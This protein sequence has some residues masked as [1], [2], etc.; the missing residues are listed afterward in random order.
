M[1]SFSNLPI[2]ALLDPKGFD[3]ACG[4][5]HACELRIFKSG[6]GVVETLP[7]VLT[8]MGVQYPF[9]V[10]DEH[11][12]EAAGARVL[13]ILD[14]AGIRYK[15]VLLRKEHLEPDEWA[16][17]AV[18]LA[19]DPACDVVL[20]VGSGVINDTCKVVAHAAGK[21]QIIVGTAPSMDG[22]ASSSSSMHVSDVKTTVYNACPVAIIADTDI[23]AQAPMRMLWA[24]F[25][26][27]IAKYV[28]IC[29]WRIAHVV[30][31]EYY[32]EEIAKLVRR[33]VK[34]IVENADRLLDRDPAVI[35]AITEGLVL[36]GVA[37]S[38]A[39]T[40]RPAS[41][42]E[43]Y[44]SHL[45]EM[46]AMERGEKADLHGIQVGVGTLTTLKLYD[47]IKTLTPDREKALAYV[48]NFDEAAWTAMVNRIFGKTAPEILRI[49]A[50]VHKN[51]PVAHE[52]RLNNIVAHWDEILGFMN[53]ELPD[54][55]EM[56]ALM[57]RLGMPMTPADLG[58]DDQDSKDAFTGAREI[59]D[60]YLSCSMLWD[61]GLT[62]E[63]RAR[64]SAT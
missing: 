50:K 36:S 4:H 37:M 41:G 48:R 46:M 38:F 20:G 28:S 24:G 32:C 42:L 14:K 26:D 9:V 15:Q 17:G 19:L 13:A 31:G 45:W 39:A 11:T 51:D 35:Q 52:R 30:I 40:S 55:A 59:R 43:H 18:T 21:P 57:S 61:M 8:Q 34:R 6:A 53:E 47:W 62:D 27:M 2:D 7:E 58:I 54:T 44:F 63:A 10:F 22:Y 25:G 49:E 16:V 60:K 56:A 29:E 1:T 64:V 33:S 3:C 5:H 12:Y 23:I